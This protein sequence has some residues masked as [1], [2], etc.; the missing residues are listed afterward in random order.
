MR[1]LISLTV[2]LGLGVGIAGPTSADTVAFADSRGDAIARFD[3]T[4]IKMTNS[5]N[6]LTV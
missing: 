1:R 4:R 3:M 2:L 6:R 5:E